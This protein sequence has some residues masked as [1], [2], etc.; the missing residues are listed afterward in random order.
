MRS[1]QSILILKPDF[2][3]T[4]VDEALENINGFIKA[5]GGEFLKVDKWGKK[6]LA[7]RV[8]KNR[9]GFYLNIYH[10]CE[11]ENVPVLEEKYRLFDSIIKYMVVRLEEDELDRV[12]KPPE[13]KA[14]ETEGDKPKE[15]SKESPKQEVPAAEKAVD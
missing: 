5:Q 7:Y 14:E 3:E 15:S 10:T 13:E 4:Q 12:M 8:K 6:R 1:Y 2:D 9:F 11:N